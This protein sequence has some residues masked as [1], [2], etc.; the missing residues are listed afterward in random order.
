[1]IQR[2]LLIGMLLLTACAKPMIRGLD[3]GDPGLVRKLGLSDQEWQE[4]QTEFRSRPDY[5]RLKSVW[6]GRSRV[7]DAVEVHC[8]DANVSSPTQGPVFFFHRFDGHWRLMGEMSEW[9]T[10]WRKR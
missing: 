9:R 3:A 1:M 8:A 2:A 6:W 5:A 7:T 4:I 10:E